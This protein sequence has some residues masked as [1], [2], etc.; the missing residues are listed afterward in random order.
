MTY[1]EKLQ[2]LRQ[3]WV[4]AKVEDRPLIE[5]RARAIKIAMAKKNERDPFIKEV[6]TSLF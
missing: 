5:R 3:D 4:K 2:E 1:E 6:V